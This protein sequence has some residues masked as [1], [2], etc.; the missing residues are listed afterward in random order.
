ML[1]LAMMKA[2]LCS[3]YALKMEMLFA[4][5]LRIVILKLFSITGWSGRTRRVN[6]HKWQD[7]MGKTLGS[8]AS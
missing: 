8:A 6:G 4:F 7:Y 3:R 5:R 1:L 2:A